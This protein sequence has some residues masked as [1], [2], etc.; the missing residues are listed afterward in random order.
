[1]DF[2][3]GRAWWLAEPT[4]PPHSGAKVLRMRR[5]R[6]LRRKKVTWAGRYRRDFGCLILDFEWKSQLAAAEA[7]LQHQKFKIQN[8]KS[9]PYRPSTSR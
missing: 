4:F 8:F 7:I 9:P 2:H 6:S 1:M 3:D 5:R